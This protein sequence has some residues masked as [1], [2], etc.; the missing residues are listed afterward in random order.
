VSHPDASQDN[1]SPAGCEQYWLRR[2]ETPCDAFVGSNV[3]FPKG[4]PAPPP[5]L[6]NTAPPCSTIEVMAREA[7]DVRDRDAPTLSLLRAHRNEIMRIAARRGVS[8]VRV[9]GSVVRGDSRPDSDIDLL[10]DFDYGHHGLDLLGFE[11]EV[12]ELVGH[13]VE[14][15]TEVHRLIRERV[16]SQAVPL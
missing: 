13:R 11:R 3:G 1:P 9:F 14:V 16:E 2:A 12:E 7:T 8:N 6:R 10:V 4:R 15:G 5:A